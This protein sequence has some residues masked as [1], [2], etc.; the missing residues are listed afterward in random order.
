MRALQARCGA[1]V[2]HALA[3]PRAAACTA[4]RRPPPSTRDARLVASRA[5]RAPAA[6]SAVRASA[7]ATDAPAETLVLA[8]DEASAHALELPVYIEFT[9]CFQV[10]AARAAARLRHVLG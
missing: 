8:C 3:P 6:A 2:T 5:A 1:A 9:D 7:A 10:R 4:A